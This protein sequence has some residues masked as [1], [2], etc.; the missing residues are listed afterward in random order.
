[1]QAQLLTSALSEVLVWPFV[2]LAS[3]L[4]YGSAIEGLKQSAEWLRANGAPKVCQT[5]KLALQM[6]T[7]VL[8]RRPSWVAL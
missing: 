7:L 1:M 2:Q 6:D 4:D 5:I 8:P 3:E